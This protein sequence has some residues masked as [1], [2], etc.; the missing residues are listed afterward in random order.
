M[1]L[2]ATARQ[3]PAV[4]AGVLRLADDV[5]P[6]AI[7]TG[8]YFPSRHHRHAH[9]ALTQAVRASKS[10]RAHDAP[11]AARVRAA[12]RRAWPTIDVDAVVT[13]PPKPSAADRMAGLRRHLAAALDVADGGE[14]LAQAFDVPGYRA[15]TIA[16]RAATARGRFVIAGDVRGLRL[17]VVDDVVASGVQGRQAVDTLLAAGAAVVRF[18]AVAAAVEAP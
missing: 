10:S 12:A 6:G 16:E 5:V 11:L 4:A 2:A 8:L 3:P 14:L 18:V 9:D 7:A 15:M 17:L 1:G 13:L